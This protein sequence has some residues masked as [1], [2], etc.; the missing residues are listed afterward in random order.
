MQTPVEQRFTIEEAAI[1]L[2]T[3]PVALRAR[4][5]RNARKH[6]KHV[7]SAIGPGVRAEKYGRSWRVVF[8]EVES[9]PRQ[10]PPKGA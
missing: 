10:T 9:N 4:C 2:S 6:G 1:F 5:R 7:I 8:S 3:S